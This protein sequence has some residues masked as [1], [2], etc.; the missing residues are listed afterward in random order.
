M[1]WGTT[2]ISLTWALEE[3]PLP[4]KPGTIILVPFSTTQPSSAGA[5]NGSGQLGLGDTSSRGDGSDEMGDNLLVVDLSSGRTAKA[6]AAGNL[7]H[8]RHTRQLI[9]QVLGV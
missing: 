2:S 1:K 5:A 3:L 9:R 4:S 7:T 6:I 8:L